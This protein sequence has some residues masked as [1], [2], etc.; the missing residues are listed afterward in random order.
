MASKKQ[1][2]KKATP[3]KKAVA[4]TESTSPA[5]MKKVVSTGKDV[6]TP[7]PAKKA[8]APKASAAPEPTMTDISKQQRRQEFLDKGFTPEEIERYPVEFM[9]NA[10]R[11]T[12]RPYDWIDKRGWRGGI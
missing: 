3:A 9:R 12:R 7:A 1:P 8:A 10:V 11:N 2:A 6:T 5:R 4:K